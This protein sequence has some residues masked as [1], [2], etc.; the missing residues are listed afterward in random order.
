MGFS[1]PEGGAKL[2]SRVIG[3]VGVEPTLTGL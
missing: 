1:A 2:P 3:A